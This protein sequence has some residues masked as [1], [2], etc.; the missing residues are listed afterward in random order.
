MF[1]K[2]TMYLLFISFCDK[3][4]MLILKMSQNI[5]KYKYIVRNLILEVLWDE[6]L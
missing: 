3:I 4:K 1:K 2:R 6:T 5:I